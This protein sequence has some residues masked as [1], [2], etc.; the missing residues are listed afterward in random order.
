[1]AV[2]SRLKHITLIVPSDKRI[3]SSSFKSL[4][5]RRYSDIQDFTSVS[6]NNGLEL[7]KMFMQE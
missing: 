7:G 2:A 3:T 5:V 1:M 4:E 6:N